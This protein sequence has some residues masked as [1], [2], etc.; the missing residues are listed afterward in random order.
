MDTAAARE[1]FP[2]GARKVSSPGSKMDRGVGG[3]GTA[4]SSI[5]R[6]RRRIPTAT[7][8]PKPGNGIA[9]DTTTAGAGASAPPVVPPTAACETGLDTR[10]AGRAS[11]GL[12]DEH[13]T[14]VSRDTA[15][16][17]GD[18]E[19]TG[20]SVSGQVAGVDTRSSEDVGGRG[21]DGKGNGQVGGDGGREELE[22]GRLTDF[23]VRFYLYKLLQALDFAH[24]RGVVHRD[25]KPRNV[26]IN[27]R[28]RTLRLIDWGLGDFY[29]PGVCVCLRKSWKMG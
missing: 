4:A 29:I 10:E 20:L 28:T 1:A 15:W 19:R 3:A 14:G 6:D 9:A 7:V 27:R 5:G 13:S 11:G 12:G 18:R 22:S 17:D 25:V 16:S 23:E 26:V 2:R 24:S 8:H 21:S